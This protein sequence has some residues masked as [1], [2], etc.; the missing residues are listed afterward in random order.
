M[1]KEVTQNN[2]RIKELSSTIE[3]MNHSNNMKTKKKDRTL[4]KI[5]DELK[6]TKK[7]QIKINSNEKIENLDRR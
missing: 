7:R 6:K 3:P 4:E 5:S 1:Q 2:D